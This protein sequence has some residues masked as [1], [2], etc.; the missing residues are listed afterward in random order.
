MPLQNER[1]P[2]LLSRSFAHVVL[3]LQ[4]GLYFYLLACW[5]CVAPLLV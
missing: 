2:H 5:L 1:I 3:I 4:S